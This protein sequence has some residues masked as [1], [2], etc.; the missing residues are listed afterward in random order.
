MSGY[1]L[2]D[3]ER[4]M[5]GAL[6][7]LKQEYQGLRTGRANAGLL[8]P[9]M[10]DAYGSSSPLSQVASVSVPEPRM[11]MVSVW[12]RGLASAVDKAIRNSGLGLNPVMEGATLRVPIPPMTEERR[13]DIAKTAAKYAE[14]TRVAIRNVRRAGIEAAKKAEKDGVMGEDQSRGISEKIQTLT[15]K[16]IK[17]VDE[18]LSAKEAEIMQV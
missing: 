2:A 5:D 16:F 4:R 8:E 9:V 10:V 12:D 1:D 11:L 15:D 3:L 7:S 14:E 17:K 18:A 6:S 13:K